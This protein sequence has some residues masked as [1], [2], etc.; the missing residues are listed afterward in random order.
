MGMFEVDVELGK[1]GAAPVS[2]LPFTLA[3][4]R[5]LER[6]TTGAVDSLTEGKLP[7]PLPLANWGRKRFF[8]APPRLRF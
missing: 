1:P 5:K 8:W 2:R 6:D 3:D 4:G 7:C